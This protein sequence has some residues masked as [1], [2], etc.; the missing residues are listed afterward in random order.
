MHLAQ[1]YGVDEWIEPVFCSFVEAPI[2]SF[3]INNV[4]LIGLRMFYLIVT[5]KNHL[6]LE[7]L[8]LAYLPP[9]LFVG[10]R[11]YVKK[12]GRNHGGSL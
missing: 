9:D 12:D 1:L 4:Q 5:T 6:D 3:M 11:I 10:I 8:Y 7:C 2:D